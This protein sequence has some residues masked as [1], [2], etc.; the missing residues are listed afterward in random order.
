MSLGSVGLRHAGRPIPT[1]SQ[2]LSLIEVAM[3]GRECNPP[4]S[5]IAGPSGGAGSDGNSEVV[6]EENKAWRGEDDG[7]CS[8]SQNAGL[9]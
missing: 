4:V 7:V 1:R 9:E 5:M 3:S 6:N 2:A 8:R